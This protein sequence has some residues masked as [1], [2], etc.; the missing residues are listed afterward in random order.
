MDEIPFGVRRTVKPSS[1]ISVDLRL[2][3]TINCD[4]ARR[5]TGVV[6]LTNHIA[7]RQRWAINHGARTRI[8]SHVLTRAGLNRSHQD[9]AV[10]LH[11]DRMKKYRN[12]NEAFLHSIQQTINPF[13]SPIDIDQLYNIATGQ[14]TTPKIAN[15]LLNAVSAGIFLRDLFITE[16]YINSVFTIV[17]PVLTPASLEEKKLKLARKYMKINCKR[18]YSVGY[19]L[20]L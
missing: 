19:W 15:S 16:C 3:Q 7:A 12:Q 4:A 18:I 13:S 8:I 11:P 6:D 20:Y 5:L 2:E 1:R 10:D 17:N 14:A 9:I